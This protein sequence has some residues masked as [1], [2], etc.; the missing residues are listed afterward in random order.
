VNKLSI[1]LSIVCLLALC[2]FS[3]ELHAAPD[4]EISHTGDTNPQDEGWRAIDIV[5]STV[6]EFDY[7]T[8]PHVGPVDDNGRPAWEINNPQGSTFET[9]A[10]WATGLGGG[11]IFFGNHWHFRA[12]VKALPA[13]DTDGNDAPELNTAF[14]IMGF[15]R[16]YFGSPIGSAWT[17]TLEDLP[18]GGTRVRSLGGAGNFVDTI[19]SDGYHTYDLIHN[20]DDGTGA[21]LYIDGTLIETNLHTSFANGNRVEFGDLIQVNSGFGG[22]Y[23]ASTYFAYDADE[24]FAPVIPEPASL[25]MLSVGGLLLARSRSRRV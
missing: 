6:T 10:Y 9:S 11:N 16:Y 8:R 13:L 19:V 24:A 12:T 4:Y 18:D 25:A 3:Y 23:W 7:T 5:A 17:I 22:G 1:A 2:G 21:S 15:S 20:P 14:R